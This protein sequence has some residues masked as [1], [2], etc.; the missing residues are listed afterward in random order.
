MTNVLRIMVD[1][2]TATLWTLTSS[3]HKEI[4]W[5]TNGSNHILNHELFMDGFNTMHSYLLR[6]VARDVIAVVANNSSKDPR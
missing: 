2:N 1:S 6:V 4:A 3:R 5:Q